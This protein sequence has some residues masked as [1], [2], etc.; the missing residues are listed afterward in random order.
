[1]LRLDTC[2]H[3]TGIQHETCEAGC[4]YEAVRDSSKPGPYRWPCLRNPE[5]PCGKREYPTQA[6]VD[7]SEAEFRA[8]YDKAM[9]DIKSGKCHVCGDDAEPSYVV[10]RCKYAACGHRIGQVMTEEP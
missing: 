3:F 5:L 6:E 8:I 1:M 7:A 4:S 9:A 10:G 2:K